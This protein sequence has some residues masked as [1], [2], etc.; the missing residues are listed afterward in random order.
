M[1]SFSTVFFANFSKNIPKLSASIALTREWVFFSTTYKNNH[2]MNFQNHTCSGK[3]SF[4]A[5]CASKLADSGM[6]TYSYEVFKRQS[7]QK[8]G[9]NFLFIFWL[10]LFTN[11]RISPWK[12]ICNCHNRLV[13]L[14]SC[15][16]ATLLRMDCFGL[17][18]YLLSRQSY[19]HNFFSS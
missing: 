18:K 15:S 19:L 3:V 13:S 2:K 7:L 16:I 5:H 17:A 6:I 10:K 11:A 9:R 12:S 1:T 4:I 14:Y 8:R